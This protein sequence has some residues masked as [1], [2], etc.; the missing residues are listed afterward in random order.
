MKKAT[1]RTDDHKKAVAR[2]KADISPGA[3]C[4]LAD[5]E[6]YCTQGGG[7]FICCKCDMYTPAET[8]TS[9]PKPQHA[10]NDTAT[11][12][13]LMDQYRVA[14][15]A[16]VE[17]ARQKLKFGAML[18]L[19]ANYLGE[20]RGRG[21]DGEGLKGWLAANCPGMNYK[22]A[23]GY[24]CKAEKAAE[25]LGGGM[26]AMAS[27]LSLCNEG[28]ALQIEAPGDVIELTEKERDAAIK[29]CENVES[30]GQLEQMY[31]D[32]MKTEDAK[33]K[34]KAVAGEPL[35]KPTRQE[36]A[37][38][39]WAGLMAQLD[40]RTALNAIVFLPP[41]DAKV[42]HDRLFELTK[43]MKAQMAVGD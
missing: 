31:F 27:L 26:R 21:K 29:L 5:A 1:K 33:A 16:D 14:V 34:R 6:G 32:F 7:G 43:A 30:L 13:Q 3:P 17:A 15:A 19:W 37:R 36:A 4:A 28:D 9:K 25:M 41:A 18:A 39:I 38:R 20:S 10:V 35:P 12:K 42:C 40:K 23:I 11:A 8:Q 24:K 22:T 2:I